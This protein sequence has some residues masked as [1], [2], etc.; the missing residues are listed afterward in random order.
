VSRYRL[1]SDLESVLARSFPLLGEADKIREIFTASLGDDRLGI[2]LA[3]DGERLRYAYLVAVLVADKPAAWGDHRIFS[4]RAL[5]PTRE[6]AI[7]QTVILGANVGTHVH[8]R[9]AAGV[10]TSVDPRATLRVRAGHGT[11]YADLA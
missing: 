6:E 4:A 1:E 10:Q 3:R 8:N 7:L 2:P 11:G 5:R 9:G